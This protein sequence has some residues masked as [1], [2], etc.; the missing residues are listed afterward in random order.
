M[1][2]RKNRRAWTSTDFNGKCAGVTVGVTHFFAA[3]NS[4]ESPGQR[5][6]AGGRVPRIGWGSIPDCAG[7]FAHGVVDVADA[8]AGQQGF[9][10]AECLVEGFDSPRKVELGGIE[11]R[12]HRG[13]KSPGHSVFEPSNLAGGSNRGSNRTR[14]VPSSRRAVDHGPLWTSTDVGGQ[15]ADRTAVGLP[16][17]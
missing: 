1:P 16:S 13:R 6:A 9:R 11:P 17:M 8:R 4:R 14:R 2:D 5:V 7:Q 10:Y 3:R 15:V 12:P